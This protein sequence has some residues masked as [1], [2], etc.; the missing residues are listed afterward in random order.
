MI[1]IPVTEAK[2]RF[3][4]ILSRTIGGERFVIERRGRPVATLI[5]QGDFEQ[6]E[7]TA[8]MALQLARALGQDESLLA[9]IASGEEHPAMAAFGLWSDDDEYLDALEKD[10]YADRG[11]P[12]ERQEVN[13]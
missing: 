9:R 8:D 13:L 10:I 5:G 4:E 6:L 11:Q 7:R 12:S 2:S 1:S 3:S